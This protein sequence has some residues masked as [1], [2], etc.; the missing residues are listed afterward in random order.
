[1]ILYSFLFPGVAKESRRGQERGEIGIGHR[2]GSESRLGRRGGWEWGLRKQPLLRCAGGWAGRLSQRHV[3]G[4]SPSGFGIPPMS[5]VL[6]LQR[7]A[8]LRSEF[9]GARDHVFILS[10]WHKFSHA[11]NVR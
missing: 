1:M 6:V 5:K 7:S 10:A 3:P 9:P 4:R 11:I 8:P 2:A